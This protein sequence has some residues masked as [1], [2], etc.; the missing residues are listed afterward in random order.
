LG[1]GNC[2]VRY[3]NSMVCSK[4]ETDATVVTPTYVPKNTN[5]N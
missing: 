4:D 3:A 2:V 1:Y 5:I